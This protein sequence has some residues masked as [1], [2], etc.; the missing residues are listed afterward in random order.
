[1]SKSPDI[2]A[3]SAYAGTNEKKLFS[4]LVN[5]MDFANDITVYKNV[6]TKVRMT[7]LRAGNGARP[8]SDTFEPTGNDLVYTNRYLEVQAG[9]RDLQ[10]FPS[11]YRETFMSEM[12]T[13][14][15]DVKEIPFAQYVMEQI[16]KENAAEINDEMV[17]FGFDKTTAVVFDAGATYTANTDYVTFSNGTTTDYYLCVSNTTAGQ[18]PLTHA[19]KWQNVNARA[20][21]VGFKKR[22]ADAVTASEVSV[23]TTG[24]IGASTALAQFRAV[25]RKLSAP[26]RKAGVNIYCSLDNADLLQDDIEDKIGKYTEKES[27]LLYLPGTNQKCKIIPATWM[28]TS[29]RLIATP[30]ENLLFGTDLLS[31]LNKIRTDEHLRHLDL[32]MDF[33]AGTQIRDFGAMVVNDQA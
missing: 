10:V 33:L 4:T 3:L 30:K 12:L 21:A 23:E 6:K 11:K 2:S 22:I 26:Y 9:K 13:P 17:Y 24:S 31:D 7:K 14:G 8:Y 18:T 25:Y 27:G 1:M 29:G 20:I 16:M 28:G 5:A 19:A 32:G 15:N